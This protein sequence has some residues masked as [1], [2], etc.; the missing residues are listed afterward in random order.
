[1][2]ERIRK[3]TVYELI[4][5]DPELSREDYSEDFMI[6]LFRTRLLAE[7]TAAFLFTKCQGLL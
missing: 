4:I 6:G 7:K 3:S 5:H 2:N 1:M